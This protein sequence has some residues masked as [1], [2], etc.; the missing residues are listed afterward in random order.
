MDGINP[1]SADVSIDVLER[2][3]NLILK[4]TKLSKFAMRQRREEF[5]IINRCNGLYN[6][7]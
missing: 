7:I 5:L 6:I 4:Q 1:E 3:I 2:H